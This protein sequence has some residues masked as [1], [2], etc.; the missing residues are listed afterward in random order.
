MAMVDEEALVAAMIY[1][2]ASE[3]KAQD[4]HHYLRLNDRIQQEDH[5]LQ[6]H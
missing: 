1:W 3:N 5:H 6:K 2:V 4:A